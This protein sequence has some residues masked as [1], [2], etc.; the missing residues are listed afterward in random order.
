MSHRDVYA[1]YFAEF[2][3]AV[4]FGKYAV[5]LKGL[6][7]ASEDEKASEALKHLRRLYREQQLHSYG[8]IPADSTLDGEPLIG[9]IMNPNR[10]RL[11]QGPVSTRL[12]EAL[13]AAMLLL[14]VLAKVLLNTDSVLPKNP[15]STA[16]AA[17]LL[18]DLNV[19]GE[20]ESGTES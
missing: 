19:L 8:R 16:A 3:R 13:L 5:P 2:F 15:C 20:Y 17:S 1:G 14:N 7:K 11:V 12:L 18:A 9:N 4:A 6:G 10:M